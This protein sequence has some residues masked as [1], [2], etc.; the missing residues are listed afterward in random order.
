MRKKTGFT[1]IELM[2]AI[3]I[4]AI[5]SVI[6][7]RIISALLIT[8]QVVT[9]SQNKWGSLARAINR[10]SGAIHGA[11]PLVIRDYN[12]AI[13]PATLG[14]SKLEQKFDAQ[15]EMTV[16]GR[17]GDAVYGIFPPKRVG[18]RFI[19]GTLYLVSWPVL[20]RVITTTPRV[21]VLLRDV[22]EFTVS[23][24]YPDMQWRDSWP[25]DVPS[26]DKLPSGIKINIVMKS[27]ES[28]LRQWSL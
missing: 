11:I 7:Y 6:S 19:G 9:D 1:L 10:I 14:R 2:I 20:N 15:L 13:I 18:F 5:I 25:L 16:S 24:L 21:D 26:V 23:F 12:G 27:G 17:V 3:M 28:I 4:F 22:S 8:K